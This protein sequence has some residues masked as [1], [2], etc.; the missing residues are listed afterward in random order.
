MDAQAGQ[1]NG[2]HEGNLLVSSS[3]VAVDRR[4]VL[5]AA[6]NRLIGREQE[7][8]RI[9][10]VL[11][12][13][14]LV[15]VTGPGGVGKTS[16]AI[17]VARDRAGD[18]ANG[19]IFV[20]LAPVRDARL[21][22]PTIALACGLPDSGSVTTVA[23]LATH[24]A[25]SN[26]LLVLDNLEQIASCALE[27]AEIL[28]QCPG[29]TCLATSRVS[30]NLQGERLLPLPPLALPAV[31]TGDDDTQ[32]LESPAVKLF[33]ERARAVDP[34]F[35]MSDANAKAIAEICVRLDGLPLAI[36][37]AAA[38]VRM[39]SP[40]ALL[41]RL[42]HRLPSCCPAVS[43]MPRPDN[44]HSAMRWPGAITCCLPGRKGS[45]PAVCLRWRIHDR[46]RRDCGRRRA[47]TREPGRAQSASDRCP[48]S[49]DRQ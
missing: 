8:A 24:L 46:G 48:V 32:S 11:R 45:S 31:V 34:G 12:V 6:P 37:L 26:L 29:I 5:P 39:F 18:Y 38:R 27:I 10:D 30:L 44:R 33:V 41:T 19:A 1:Q 22:I 36:E 43:G 2:R 13:S 42:H 47:S 21:L 35:E 49:A 15:T 3:T 23:K 25:E 20:S 28:E 16:V 14:R 9:G 4:I 7:I 40:A 17:E